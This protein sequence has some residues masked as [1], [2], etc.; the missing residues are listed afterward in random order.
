MRSRSSTLTLLAALALPL[1]TYAEPPPI[2][3]RSDF[4]AESRIDDPLFIAGALTFAA[5]YGI[6]VGVA[7][8]SLD[9]DDRGLYVPVVGPW[10]ALAAH[11]PCD[12]G[13]ADDTR[14]DV[15]LTLDG[16]AQL[17]GVALMVTSLVRERDESARVRDARLVITSR[18]VGVAARF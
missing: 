13:C 15:L 14:D 5:S 18:S 6:A 9:R 2:G 3:D 1:S 7:A 17:A 4:E 16:V 10:A 12:G 11:H 8:S